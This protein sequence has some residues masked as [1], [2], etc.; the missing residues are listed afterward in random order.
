M[1]RE[2]SVTGATVTRTAMGTVPTVRSVITV[3]V[4]IA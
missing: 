4:T 1:N 2:R 3:T